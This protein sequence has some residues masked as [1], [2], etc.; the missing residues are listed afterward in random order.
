MSLTSFL[1]NSLDDSLDNSLDDDYNLPLFQVC[2]Y[3]HP[4]LKKGFSTINAMLELEYLELCND[5]LNFTPAGIDYMFTKQDEFIQYMT[6]DMNHR[7]DPNTAFNLGL[8]NYN[9]ERLTEQLLDE[10]KRRSI[11]HPGNLMSYKLYLNNRLDYD[12]EDNVDYN[13][14]VFKKKAEDEIICPD[15]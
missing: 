5:G 14:I 2:S 3:D 7:F 12:V 1:D 10:N 6:N 13:N 9:V 11:N 8:N 15:I 4:A